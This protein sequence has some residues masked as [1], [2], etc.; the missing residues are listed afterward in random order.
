MNYEIEREAHVHGEQW[1]R[2]A[3]GFFA[4][5]DMARNY[6]A[7]ILR[8]AR[9]APP[10]A[11]VDL[12]GGTGFILEQLIQQGLAEQVRL[13]DMD[14]S[15]TQLA[16]C[17]HPR[18]T[19]IQGALETLDRR[20]ILPE[21]GR[22]MLIC[23]SVLHYGGLARQKAWLRHL[24]GQLEPGEW[25]VHQSGCALEVEHS[26]ALD[27]LF[28][29][30]G[31]DKWVPSKAAFLQLLEEAG[32][33]CEDVFPVPPVPMGRAD[34]VMRY[35]ATPEVMARVDDDLRRTCAGKPHIVEFTASG[36]IFYFPYLVFVCRAA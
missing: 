27:A 3:A 21:P 10:A 31:V 23:R 24:R 28:E 19:P 30:L 25:F 1:A 13:V 26:L 7:A 11:I 17:R 16:L 34:L 33:A 14:E 22:L 35:G 36:F 4:N 32:F 2:V 9:Q 8:V 29:Q 20:R 5:P 12:G 15:A 6:V 18:I